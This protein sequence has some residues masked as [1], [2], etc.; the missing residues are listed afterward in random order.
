MVTMILPGGKRAKKAQ[1]CP[2]SRSIARRALK[3]D[4]D[5]QHELPPGRHTAL[6][7]DGT[8]LLTDKSYVSQ[9]KIGVNY[10]FS[11]PATVVAKY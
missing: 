1:G 7:T 6:A 10:R 11:G 5:H 4:T 3:A 9:V 8:T 2:G